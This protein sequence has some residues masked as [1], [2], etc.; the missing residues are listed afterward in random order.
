MTNDEWLKLRDEAAKEYAKPFLGVKG[1]HEKY[2][3]AVREQTF[4]DGADFGRAHG[5]AEERK[6]SKKLLEALKDMIRNSRDIVAKKQCSDY[7]AL[8]EAGEVK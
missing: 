4:S 2:L 5:I 7:L 1:E 3:C 6:R 8:Y